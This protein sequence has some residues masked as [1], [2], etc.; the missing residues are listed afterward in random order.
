MKPHRRIWMTHPWTPLIVMIF[1]PATIVTV[2][3]L[4]AFLGAWRTGGPGPALLLAL[5][6]F[7]TP[8]IL[9]AY[10]PPVLG[11]LAYG[12]LLRWGSLPTSSHDAYR[13]LL[14]FEGRD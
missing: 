12:L 14:W 6:F 13:P 2:F 11:A 9:V 8:G 5:R 1:M 10:A 4:A 3:G 7:T